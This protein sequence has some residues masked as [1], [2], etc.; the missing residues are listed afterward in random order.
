MKQGK[1]FNFKVEKAAEEAL[2]Y[3]MNK[4]FNSASEIAKKNLKKKNKHPVF[5]FTESIDALIQSNEELF[6]LKFDELSKLSSVRYSDYYNFGVFFQQHDLDNLAVECFSHCVHFKED[7]FEG[8]EQLGNSVFKLE[9]YDGALG[10]YT[11]ALELDPDN[12]IIMARLAKCC[13]NL[14]HHADGL[15]Y[16]KRLLVDNP[17]DSNIRT[18]FASCLNGLGRENEA[19]SLLG[20]GIDKASQPEMDY[21]LLSLIAFKNFKLH[22]AFTFSGKAHEINPDYLPA[23]KMYGLVLGRLNIH[24]KSVEILKKARAKDPDDIDVIFNYGNALRSMGK[25][26]DALECYF[27]CL[28]LN[29][30]Y[31]YAFNNLGHT[32]TLMGDSLKARE[33]Y[34]I[35]MELAPDRSDYH[36]N[37]LF[38]ILHEK[39]VTSEDHLKEAR[40]W[41]NKHAASI[42]ERVQNYK[43]N[44]GKV[45]KLRIGYISGDFGN[46]VVSYYWLPVVEH[47]DRNKFEIFLYSQES[48]EDNISKNINAEIEQVYDKRR[49]VSGLSDDK[50]CEQIVDD[51]IHILVDLSGHTASNRLK[52]LSYKPAPIQASYIGYPA[53]TG[54]DSIDY[55]ITQPLSVPLEYEDLFVEKLAHVAGYTSYNLREGSEAILSRE[56][57]YKKNGYITFAN[58]NRAGKATSVCIETWGE[59][60]QQVPESRLMIKVDNLEGDK[61][62]N[63]LYEC[64]DR[65]GIERDRL[66]L[67]ARSHFLEYLEE[68]NEFDIGLDPF[69]YNGASTSLD[70]LY[71]GR[72]FIALAKERAF[73]ENIGAS[74]LR[75]F[76]QEEMI[77]SS[78]EQYVER[79][80]WAAKNVEI[81]ESRRLS[82]RAFF[83]S[84]VSANGAKVCAS[85]ENAF[86]K[87]W[88]KYC[89][90]EAPS[91][92]PLEE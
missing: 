9:D 8:Y 31:S 19:V 66:I 68:M 21:Y 42:D 36:S 78:L 37:L 15:A 34:G 52:A 39:N 2:Q 87:M 17:Y 7:F 57:P 86:E 3:L 56:L 40:K 43:F 4:E 24:D 77:A 18:G 65:L 61:F 44:P 67:K 69:P 92:I 26:S 41:Q 12:H 82:L 28:H 33:C 14:G 73:H 58:F 75:F 62:T 10:A 51:Q 46:H 45:E 20:K 13:V 54:L 35:A 90:G 81:L 60:L 48:R 85:L 25:L 30:E 64:I 29:P 23:L 49:D 72:N 89:N 59:I 55:Y 32:Y 38:T 63:D 1:K 74:L 88:S 80:V 47:H 84:E 16:Y 6:R 71:M 79:A 70:L 91:H 50:L 76:G 11:K 53:T 27:E 83:L 5:L 22:S